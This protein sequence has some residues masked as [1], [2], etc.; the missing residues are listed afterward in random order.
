M[1][2][3]SQKRDTTA[4]DDTGTG[5]MLMMDGWLLNNLAVEYY[6]IM[7]SRNDLGEMG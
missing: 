4:I 2:C 5:M 6:A 7:E 1:V 3:G